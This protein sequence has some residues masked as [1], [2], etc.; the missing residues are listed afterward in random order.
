LKS[1]K[2][3]YQSNAL[4]TLPQ[5]AVWPAELQEILREGFPKEYRS[6]E[7]VVRLT[8]EDRLAFLLFL[9]L[10]HG[11]NSRASLER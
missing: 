11:A 8:S 10:F 9:C 6:L 5:G 4:V 3:A 1:D 7:D 2:L